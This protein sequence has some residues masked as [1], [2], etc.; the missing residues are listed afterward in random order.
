VLLN[1]ANGSYYGLNHIGANLIKAF[2]AH[3]PLESAVQQIS[4]Q[5]QMEYSVVDRDFAQLI[6]QLLEQNLIIQKEST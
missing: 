2:E 3:I 4:E 1:L 6:M 5:Y